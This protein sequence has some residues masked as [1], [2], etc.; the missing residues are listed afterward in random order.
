[1]VARVTAPAERGRVLGWVHLWWNAAMVLGSLVG[2]ALFERG[3]GLP[4]GVAG[5]G[6]LLAG[7]LAALF[8]RRTA[9]LSPA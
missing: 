5:A 1:M 8:F 4:F 2:G 7:G 3:A 9:A 6:V